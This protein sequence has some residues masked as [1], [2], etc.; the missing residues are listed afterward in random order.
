MFWCD[1]TWF[2]RA[3]AINCKSRMSGRSVVCVWTIKVKSSLLY[4][5]LSVLF[6]L[7]NFF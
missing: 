6:Y 7:N 5:V 1:Q 3:G 2:A 4:Y